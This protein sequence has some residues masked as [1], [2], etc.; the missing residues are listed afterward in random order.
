MTSNFRRAL[1]VSVREG[2]L[3]TPPRTFAWRGEQHYVDDVPVSER[4]YELAY[5]DRLA[6]ARAAWLQEVEIP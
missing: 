4:V 1:F 5:H 3:L 6:E 2:F